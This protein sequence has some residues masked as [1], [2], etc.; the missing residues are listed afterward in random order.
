MMPNWR[1]LSLPS[2][3]V[4][5]ILS[6]MLAVIL[7]V[8]PVAST[9]APVQNSPVF[10]GAGDIASCYDDNDE[11]TA[12]LLDGIEGAVFTLGDNAYDEGRLEE[13]ASCYDPTWGRHLDRTHPVPGN[14]DYYTPGAAGYFGY[15]GARA[16]DPDEGYYSFDL[17]A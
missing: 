13:F 7:V 6:M 9:P 3:A 15:F 11:A 5:C 12:R 14:H 8:S 4:R 1:S 16:G 10:V 2:S 17:G